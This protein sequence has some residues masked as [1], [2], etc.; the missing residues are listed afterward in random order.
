MRS[1]A[2][3]AL[4]LSKALGNNNKPAI[5]VK[6][7][8][9]LWECLLE[10]VTGKDVCYSAVKRFFSKVD[11]DAIAMVSEADQAHFADGESFECRQ[12]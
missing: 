11:W 10:I 1:I 5:V 8:N 7:K 3:P 4:Q 2:Y 9:L 12:N 6:T